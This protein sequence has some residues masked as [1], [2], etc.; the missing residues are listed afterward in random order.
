M[1]P[2][3]NDVL[4]GLRALDDETLLAVG[5]TTLKN[6]RLAAENGNAPLA[7]LH[8]LVSVLVDRALLERAASG[9]DPHISQAQISSYM[10]ETE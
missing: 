8:G 7:S 2:G 10:D 4:S 9:Q 6:R 3:S 1:P 5:Y